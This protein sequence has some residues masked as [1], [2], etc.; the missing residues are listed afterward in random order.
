M[1]KKFALSILIFAFYG[2]AAKDWGA[3]QAFPNHQQLVGVYFW[4][5]GMGANEVLTLHSDGTFTQEF[6]GHLTQ[7]STSLR[8]VWRSREKHVFFYSPDGTFPPRRGGLTYGETF[9]FEGK[10]AFVGEADIGKKGVSRSWV[11][12]WQR[13]PDA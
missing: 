8:G 11:Y 10:P 3:R 1:W 9:F 5:D 2:C 13:R 6:P 12:K 7:Q 4:G